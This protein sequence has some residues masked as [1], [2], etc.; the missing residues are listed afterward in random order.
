MI[1][2]EKLGG[3]S[4]V[5]LPTG[6]LFGELK[7]KVHLDD[8]EASQ[9]LTK[10]VHLALLKFEGFPETVYEAE[11]VA[12][13]QYDLRKVDSF[14]VKLSQQCV[15]DQTLKPSMKEAVN[16][17]FKV[18]RKKFCYYHYAIDKL[19]RKD[20]LFPPRNMFPRYVYA[21]KHGPLQVQHIHHCI[22]EVI[23]PIDCEIL[24]FVKCN[25]FLAYQVFVVTLD[26]K[27]CVYV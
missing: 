1:V 16:V 21:Y 24:L 10:S 9:I 18:D 7:W 5:K 3:N 19:K 26:I 25:L 23:V 17:Q 13:M 6:Q 20:L 27:A 2:K 14:V 12:G 8:S 4:R 15:S 11:I 22:F